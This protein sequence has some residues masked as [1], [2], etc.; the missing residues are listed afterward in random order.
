MMFQLYGTRQSNPDA[1]SKRQAIAFSP[2]EEH[3]NLCARLYQLCY[4]IW[5]GVNGWFD[6]PVWSIHKGK[7]TTQVSP[8]CNENAHVLPEV[9][10]LDED[11][12][13]AIDVLEEIGLRESVEFMM[14][15]GM[16]Y[17]LNNHVVYH[18]R[19]SWRFNGDTDADKTQTKEGA[20]GGRLMLRM[21]ISPYETRELPSTEK[22]KLCWGSTEAGVLR[23]GLEPA[24]KSGLSPQRKELVDA[25]SSGKVDY[26]GLFRCKYG[27][28]AFE[29]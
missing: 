16:V 11:G 14:Q 5:D 10:R 12:I 1:Y 17:W 20:D 6:L 9:P 21:W 7:F 13:E 28:D 18:G 27:L 2:A 19:D 22:Y 26:Y 4:R 8:S 29:V 24:I 25:V 15:T 23:G 3:P